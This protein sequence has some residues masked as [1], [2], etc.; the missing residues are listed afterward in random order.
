M[1]INRTNVYQF[2]ISRRLV[3]LGFSKHIYTTESVKFKFFQES[4]QIN[5]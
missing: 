5:I 3:L 4:C 1:L 2:I